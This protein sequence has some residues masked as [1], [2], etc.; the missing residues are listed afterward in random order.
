M[1]MTI[2]K[3]CV[4]V[5]VVL[6]IIVVFGVNVYAAK[7]LTVSEDGKSSILININ[8]AGTEDLVKLPRIGEKMA[9]RIIEFREK[10]GKFKKIQELMK[11][12][13]IGEKT[14]KR[15]EKLVTI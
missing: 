3:K 14:F 2:L 5:L 7:K 8:T 6:G 1:T 12:K 11:V 4:S 10:N 9:K 15:F 13:G